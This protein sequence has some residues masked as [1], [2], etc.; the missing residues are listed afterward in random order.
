MSN[1]IRTLIVIILSSMVFSG[2]ILSQSSSEL[3]QSGFTNY[4][5]GDYNAAIKNFDKALQNY[6]SGSTK[7][8]TT[9]SRETYTSGNNETSTGISKRQST[10]TSI[11]TY[12]GI[13]KRETMSTETK[14]YES[15]P[16]E[17]QGDEPAKIYLYRGRTYIQLGNKQ[18]ALNDFDKAVSL[19]PTLSEVYFRRAIAEMDVDPDKACPDLLAAIERGH[20]SAK[21]LYDLICK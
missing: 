10:T 14:K 17:Y 18:A 11:K 12:T 5:N 7:Q 6:N 20:K 16:L 9:E 13:S 15:T 3:V 8:I 2:K 4:Q 1:I 19:D 21:E